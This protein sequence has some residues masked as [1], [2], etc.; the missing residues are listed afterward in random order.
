MQ[1]DTEK[2]GCISKGSTVAKNTFQTFRRIADTSS[3]QIS[4]VTSAYHGLVA[5]QTRLNDISTRIAH[6]GTP[7]T[8]SLSDDAVALI[9]VRNS[10]KAQ[11]NVI[12]VTDEMERAV[13]SL[14]GAGHVEAGKTR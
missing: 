11:T 6:D 10:A 9:E 3:M 8:V 7:D 2:F 12:A 14:I 4:A 1:S 13:L 5:A